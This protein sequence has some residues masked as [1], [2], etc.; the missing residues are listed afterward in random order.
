MIKSKGLEDFLKEDPSLTKEITYEEFESNQKVVN[1]ED[2]GI[3]ESYDAYKD[4]Q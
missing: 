4:T 3:E 2:D 1:I